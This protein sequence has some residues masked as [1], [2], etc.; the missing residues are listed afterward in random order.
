MVNLIAST[1]ASTNR[2]PVY[3]HSLDHSDLDPPPPPPLSRLLFALIPSQQLSA[4]SSGALPTPGDR[5]ANC[6]LQPHD[7][8]YSRH[9]ANIDAKFCSPW[10]T[11]S[12]KISGSP[13]VLDSSTILFQHHEAS[14][15]HPKATA[16]LQI[17]RRLDHKM[18]PKTQRVQPRTG[19]L[20]KLLLS[21][22]NQAKLNL[23]PRLPM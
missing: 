18:Q 1:L 17:L 15:F 20:H 8:Q 23:L 10:H 13:L 5:A 12:H 19:R 22:P 3:L 2:R 4:R 7:R 6:K 16:Q 9:V 11:N 21:Q 14:L